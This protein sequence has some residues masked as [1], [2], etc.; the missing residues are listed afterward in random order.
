MYVP[1]FRYQFLRDGDTY[2]VA[3]GGV[4]GI[5]PKS[6]K[7]NDGRKPTDGERRR[8]E[9]ELRLIN[10]CSF[11]GHPNAG[12]TSLLAALSRAHTR[13][14]PEEYSTTR[15]HVGVV[16]FR[17]Q[18]E[19][20]LCDLPGLKEGASED[21]LMGRRILQHTYRSRVLVFV[22]NMARGQHSDHDT[23][24]EVEALRREAIAYDP[25]NEQKPWMVVGTKCDALHRD[26]MF[27]LDS[28]HFRLRARYGDIPVVGTSARFGL[29]LTRLVR[30]LR[31]LLYP[32]LLEARRRLPAE[33][34]VTQLPGVL[35]EPFTDPLPSIDG[36]HWTPQLMLPQTDGKGPGTVKVI[37]E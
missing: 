22:V 17:D 33:R 8:I 5:G 18:V 28:L 2:L 27:H 37:E 9:L 12:K 35:H 30:T 29:G 31:Q 19:M 32:D 24:Q 11:L 1:Q 21:K 26:A 6:F 34:F 15:P 25:L 20:R 3:R 10:D 7:L 23:L 13:I 36:K 16:R 4:G 14:G